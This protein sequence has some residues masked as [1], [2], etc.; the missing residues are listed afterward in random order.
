MNFCHLNYNNIK[1]NDQLL[2][3]YPTPIINDVCLLEVKSRQIMISTQQ[4]QDHVKITVI[5]MTDFDSQFILVGAAFATDKGWYISLSRN[6]G[7]IGPRFI[8][9]VRRFSYTRTVK[10]I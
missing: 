3:I 4:N 9:K 10:L 7:V 1:F 6:S 2:L 5:K 8:Q